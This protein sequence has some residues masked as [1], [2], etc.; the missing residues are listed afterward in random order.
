MHEELIVTG[1]ANYSDERKVRLALDFL[2]D[3]YPVRLVI[4]TGGGGAEAFA[5]KW[6][7][8]HM[9]SFFTLPAEW[10]TLEEYPTAT[11][12]YFLD[13]LMARLEEERFRDGPKTGGLSYF[14]RQEQLSGRSKRAR[15][16]GE[17]LARLQEAY[18][19]ELF[20]AVESQV[21]K[22]PREYS[23]PGA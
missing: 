14:I 12:V 18:E 5:R 19:R 23:G 22:Q 13:P 15:F 10:E 6:A 8:V 1:S 9:V 4:Q 17:T 20:G 3:S 11:E 16:D 2:N 21:A 7:Q